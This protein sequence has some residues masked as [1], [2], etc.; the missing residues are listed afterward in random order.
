[1]QKNTQY[2]IVVVVVLLL[3]DAVVIGLYVYEVRREKGIEKR[4]LKCLQDCETAR[5]ACGLSGK[6]IELE[7]LQ[8]QLAGKVLCSDGTKRS[9]D[10]CVASCKGKDDVDLFSV[11]IGIGIAACLVS[12]MWA[13]PDQSQAVI[14]RGRSLATSARNRVS[15]WFV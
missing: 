11:T 3:C 12:L 10:R 4:N 1:M 7:S 14:D 6:R 5:E 9:G 8:R 13:R 15:G 2:L